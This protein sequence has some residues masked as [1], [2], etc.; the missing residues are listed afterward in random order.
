M[1]GHQEDG[2]GV[3]WGGAKKRPAQQSQHKTKQSRYLA[4][5]G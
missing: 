2:D 5:Q 3:E 1:P 4:Q